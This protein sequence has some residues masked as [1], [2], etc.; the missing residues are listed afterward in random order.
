VRFEK[1]ERENNFQ[2]AEFWA[3]LAQFCIF[4]AFAQSHRDCPSTTGILKNL[5]SAA[6]FAFE[7]E[8]K[9]LTWLKDT[10]KK[11][12]V[13][14]MGGAKIHDKLDLLECLLP[15]ADNIFLGGALANTV[16]KATGV[17]VGNSLIDEKADF[18]KLKQLSTNPKILL[19]VDL[20][21]AEKVEQSAKSKNIELAT[22]KVPESWFCLDIGEKTIDRY[23]EIIKKSNTLFWNGP[24]GYCEIE[25]FDFG[26]VELGFAA[27]QVKNSYVGGGDTVAA[28]DG[29]IDQF[30]FVSMGGGATLEFLA[31]KKLPVLKYLE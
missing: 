30:N 20:I 1:A 2:I 31:G 13:V 15:I 19:P 11:P 21:A 6:G 4:E 10:P 14:V 28:L 27:S 9:N 5:P 26:T 25:K 23:R 8:I 17:F 7:K 12:Y 18:E 22:E 16:L 24:V 29:K 3:S